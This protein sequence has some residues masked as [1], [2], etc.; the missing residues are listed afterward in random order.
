M[1]YSSE[2]SFIVLF[3]DYHC[4]S[5]KKTYND[6]KKKKNMLKV[7]QKLLNSARSLQSDWLDVTNQ[8]MVNIETA[9]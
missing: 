7:S 2:E 6:K 3:C 5:K 9:A 1:S 8:V 4:D